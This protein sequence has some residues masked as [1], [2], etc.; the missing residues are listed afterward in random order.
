[1]LVAVTFRMASRGLRIF[2]SETR[3]TSS[4]SLPHQL[5]A[6]MAGP[7]RLAVGGRDFTGLHELFEIAQ[8]LAHLAVGTSAE[9]LRQRGADHTGRPVVP[10]SHAHCPSQA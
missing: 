7:P 5:T 10:D 2:G 8:A 9:R 3:S 1:M 4:V 6:C